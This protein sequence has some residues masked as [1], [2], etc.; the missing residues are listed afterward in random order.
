MLGRDASPE[1]YEK[2]LDK[3][4]KEKIFN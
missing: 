2:E 4:M 1:I 3:D